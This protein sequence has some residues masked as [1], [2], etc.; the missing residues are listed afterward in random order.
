MGS[1]EFGVQIRLIGTTWREVEAV[2]RTIDAGPWRSLWTGDHLVAVLGDEREACFEAWA[3]LAGF[4]T[5]TERVRLGVLVSSNTFRNPALL[6][7]MAVTVDHMSGGRLEL[8]IGAGYHRREHAAYGLEFPPG[9]A[10]FD[11]LDE[12]CEVIHRLLTEEGPLDYRGRYYQLDAA[13]FGPRC[14]QRPRA[15]I[16]VAGGGEQRTFRTLARFGDVMNVV[17]STPEELRR[18]I[19][20]LE[21]RCAEVGRNPAEI[22]KTILTFTGVTDDSA[23]ADRL[24]RRF[25]RFVRTDEAE[26]ALPVGTA[27]EVAEKLRA[28]AEA[29]AE[30]IIVT[31][32]PNSVE[33]YER[34]AEEVL[35]RLT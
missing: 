20:V 34:I 32:L 24:R 25:R 7:K 9:A 13:P 21:E 8:G 26:R 27:A 29:G 17:A 23:E 10:R 6:A 35:G 4:A 5:V 30:E 3:A 2:A 31:D 28:F 22:R 16:V 12:A 1:V 19:A 18:K 14:L 33:G 15:P 11:M